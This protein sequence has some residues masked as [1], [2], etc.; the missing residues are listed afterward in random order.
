MSVNALGALN[1]GGVSARTLAA[2]GSVHGAVD[3]LDATFRSPVVP[4]LSIWF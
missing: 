1:L 3:R 2:A 4:Y